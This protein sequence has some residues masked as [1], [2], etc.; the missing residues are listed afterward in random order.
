[1]IKQGCGVIIHISSIQST[2]PLY[3]STLAYA[4]AKAALTNYSKALSNEI[5]SNVF[6]TIY[7]RLGIKTNINDEKEIFALF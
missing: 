6:K 7:K 2:L 5:A 4:A 1:M 3:D